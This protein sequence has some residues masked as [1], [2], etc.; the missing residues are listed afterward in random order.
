MADRI[1]RKP[2]T[3]YLAACR[4]GRLLFS[5]GYPRWIVR[6]RVNGEDA[7]ADA[8]TADTFCGCCTRHWV[9]KFKEVVE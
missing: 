9:V 7:H 6:A 8:R 2:R 3:L 4:D 1:K 5:G